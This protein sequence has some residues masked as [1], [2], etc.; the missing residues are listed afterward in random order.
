MKFIHA[1]ILHAWLVIRLKHNGDGMPTQIPS[2]V[3]LVTLYT[4]LMLI[5]KHLLQG[6]TLEAIIG[7]SFISQCY[8]FNLRNKVVGLIILIG[9]ITNTVTIALIAFTN[10]AEHQLYIIT[11]LEYIMIFFSII[12]VIKSNVKVY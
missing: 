9:I 10:I 2:A 11:L 6:I 12:N 5:E 3:A 8:I 1:L 7:L 4:L